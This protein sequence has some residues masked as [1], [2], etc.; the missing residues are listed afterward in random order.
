MQKPTKKSYCLYNDHTM[1]FE[2]YGNNLKWIKKI[3]AGLEENKF[4]SYFQPIID[5][6]TLKVVKFESLIRLMDSENKPI[7]PYFFLDIAKKTKLYSSLTHAVMTHACNFIQGRSESIS[8]NLSLADIINETTV[9]FL[10][11]IILDN[12]LQNKIIFEIVESEGIE[13]ESRVVAFIKKMKGHGCQF[14]IDD[15]GTGY[16]NLARLRELPIDRIKVDRSFVHNLEGDSNAQAI[17][18]C[19]VTMAKVMNL[20]VVAE[21]VETA[22]QLRQLLQQGCHSIQGY[23]F[24]RPMLPES[25]DGWIGD[26]GLHDGEKHV[27]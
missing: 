14:A 15:F 1:N 11:Q 6:K 23:L 9:V 8:V 2:Q 21:G 16:S 10:E 17:S 13:E 27:A 22:G 7:S 4:V 26:M 25:I 18:T 12:A 19:I 20:E 3:K 5:N 24:A